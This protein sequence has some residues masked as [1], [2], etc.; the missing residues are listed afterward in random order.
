MKKLLHDSDLG[1]PSTGHSNRAMIRLIK[2]FVGVKALNALYGATE[3][4][5]LNFVRSCL[6]QLNIS[7]EWSTES[8]SKIPETGP[9]I[10]VANL[11]HG[12]LDG[13]AIL[14]LILSK[15]PDAKLVGNF[16]LTFIPELKQQILSVD[17]FESRHHSNLSGVRQACQHLEAGHP[18]ILFPA[19][20]LTTFKTGLSG[21]APRTT[22]N[23]ASLKFLLHCNVPIIPV[24]ID[25]K[26]SL[27]F[28]LLGRANHKIQL[29][30]A[31]RELLNQEGHEVTLEVGNAIEISSR[32]PLTNPTK[33]EAYLRANITLLG[34]RTRINNRAVVLSEH[35]RE[36][37][38]LSI[39]HLTL[40]SFD[41]KLTPQNLL[42]TQQ[43]FDIYWIEESVIESALPELLSEKNNPAPHY[44]L[45]IDR[46][47]NDPIGLAEIRYG[48][49]TMLAHGIDGLYTH[50]YFEYSHKYFDVIRSSIELGERYA[51]SDWRQDKQLSEL[52][53]RAAVILLS[54]N[55]QY[56]YLLGTSG[57][58]ANYS[59]LAKLLIAS[60]IHTHHTDNKRFA[61]MAVAR[62]SAKR[63]HRPLFEGGMI[64]QLK[65]IDLA[66]KLIADSDPHY[67]QMPSTLEHLLRQGAHVLT[68]SINHKDRGK[69]NALMLVDIEELRGNSVSRGT[70]NTENW[71]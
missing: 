3:G 12:A 46:A 61:F 60:Y 30:R 58:S 55:A 44:I 41:G 17:N 38:D 16:P 19:Q 8:L 69:L 9:F 11:P 13:L 10:I 22:W 54:K 24:H 56:H 42:F 2:S 65:E 52:F 62:H 29:L 28:R 40:Q 47:K 34:Q 57:I 31:G 53:W 18:L 4:E 70:T 51:K 5:G 25:G 7:T 49:Q 33:L 68:L 71:I 26:N 64:E 39:D 15:R 23:Q 21:E 14:N 36:R 1:I 27:W 35:L 43:T 50:R 66:N 48:N 63:Y 6:K 20:E 32:T 45:V 37:E 67:N 59:N